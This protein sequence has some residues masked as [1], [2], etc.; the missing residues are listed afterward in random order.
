MIEKKSSEYNNR[1][2]CNPTAVLTK[3]HFQP[4]YTKHEEKNDNVKYNNLEHAEC[5][6]LSFHLMTITTAPPISIVQ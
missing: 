5:M 6:C 2:E 4:G 1:F 3:W